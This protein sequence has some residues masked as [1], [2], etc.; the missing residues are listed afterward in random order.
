MN[1]VR[2]RGRPPHADQLTPAEWRVVESVR[3]GLTNPA[4]A[5]RLAISPDAVK[6][7]VTNA[8]QKLGFARR[9]E[10]RQWEGVR[11]DSLLFSAPVTVDAPVK[12]GMI[13]QIGRN[14][15]SLVAAETWY[16]DVLGL[17]HLYTFHPM[18]FFDCGGVRLMLNE[19]PAAGQSLLYFR[20]DD[21]RTAYPELAA[22]GV[23]FINAPHLIHTHADDTEEW[24][25]FF[26]DNENRP[27]AIMARV[28]AP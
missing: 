6:F 15:S 28:A 26:N 20:V 3:H 18:A 4:I 25:A 22:R 1:P 13:G 11:R 21:V 9:A 19:G 2:P 12:L 14:V 10:L 7:H 8:L 24:M 5:R 27:L 16:R 23:E 17:T